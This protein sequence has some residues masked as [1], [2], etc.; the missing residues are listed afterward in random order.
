MFVKKKTCFVFV[1]IFAS[2]V[3]H[4]FL[5]SPFL[6][7]V[8]SFWDSF[9]WCFLFDIGFCVFGFV[10]FWIG[11]LFFQVILLFYSPPEVRPKPAEKVARKPTKRTSK[12]SEKLMKSTTCNTNS[13]EKKH[14]PKVH[15][16]CTKSPPEVYQ[17][18]IRSLWEVRQKTV[19]SPSEVRQE[20]VRSPSKSQSF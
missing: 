4:S 16:K 10:G 9:D 3:C 6:W 20:S 1:I 2:F 14:L 5:L 15:K 11:L 8:F 12:V 7:I 13:W 18:S 17:K 19:R